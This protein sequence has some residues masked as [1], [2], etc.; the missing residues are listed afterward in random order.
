MLTFAKKSAIKKYRF[1]KCKIHASMDRLPAPFISNDV[2]NSTKPLALSAT[3][4]INR[5]EIRMNARLYGQTSFSATE[6]S[7]CSIVDIF[8]ETVIFL[9]A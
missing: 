9:V 7:H 4:Y 6:R 2:H 8:W 3:F 1:G 5:S